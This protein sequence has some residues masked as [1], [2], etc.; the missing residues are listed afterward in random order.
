VFIEP[1]LT[2]NWI[3]VIKPDFASAMAKLFQQLNHRFWCIGVVT[4]TGQ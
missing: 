4:G 3:A 1:R 2:G